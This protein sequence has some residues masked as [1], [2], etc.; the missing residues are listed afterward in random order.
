[1][2]G[3][4]KVLEALCDIFP[5][6][7]IYT[8]VYNPKNISEKIK[9]HKIQTT[10]IN[11]LPFAKKL[12]PYYLLLMPYAL[13]KL[14][15]N[16]YNLIIS[17]ES[18][19]AKGISPVKDVY[20]I[21]Y[22][23][24]PMRYIWDLYHDYYDKSNALVRFF[25]RTFVMRLRIWDVQTA[26]NVNV[27]I[28]NSKFVA[29]RIQQYY[30]R[31]SIVVFPPVSV[32][33]FLNIPRVPENFYLFFGQLTKYKRLDLAIKACILINRRLIIVGSGT[34]I[35]EN[36]NGLI[37]YKGN[38]SDDEI[39]MLLTRAKALLFPGIEDFGIIPVEAMA[40]G[41]PVIA[42][43]KGGAL[44]TVLEN[45]TGIF[46]D[47]QSPEALAKAIIEL[48][49]KYSQFCDIVQY[50]KHVKQFSKECFDE[51]IKKIVKEKI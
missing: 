36:K 31:D 6:A 33:K 51:K 39:V 16:D 20:H 5:T 41:C 37:K 9:S 40:V 35:K 24:T 48:E 3:G 44:E 32:E 21:C 34:K 28:A 50:Q 13:K 10:F 14:N 47:E 7:D 25:M 46:F 49:S 23:H 29:R 26:G 45:V 30:G 42:Y 19:P 27:F 11:K 22:C 4:E 8:H 2:R 18:G 15:L 38:L 12:Y 43:R 1:M 17:S